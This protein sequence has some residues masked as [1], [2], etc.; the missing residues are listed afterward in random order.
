MRRNLKVV[1]ASLV[2]V[3]VTLAC[4]ISSL[5]QAVLDNTQEPTATAFPVLP[6][7]TRNLTPAVTGDLSDLDATLTELYERVNPGVVFIQTITANG[8]GLGSGFVYDKAGHIITNYHVVEGATTVEVDFPSGL[9]LFGDVIATDGDTDLAIIK[10]QTNPDNLVPLV[11]GDSEALKVGQTVVA[12]GNPFGLSGT[13]TLGIISAKGRVLSSVREVPGSGGYYSAGDILQTDASINPGNSGGPLLNINGEVVGINRAIEVS[14]VTLDGSAVNS[15]IGYAISINLVKRV[16]PAL[17]SKGVYDYPY[18]GITPIDELNLT[19]MEALGI[20][21]PNGAY[22]LGVAEGGPADK[23]GI[24]GG[25]TES[26]I[27]GL[28][29]GGDL[30]IGMDGIPVRNFSEL[31]SYMINYKSPGD[32]MVLTIIRDNREMEVTLTLEKRP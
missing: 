7:P 5:D 28:Y 20:E 8:S 10:V 14:G 27:T 3:T 22:V 25:T 32:K 1:L 29:S 9:K 12:I 23:A 15:G 4:S 6:T 11:L 2:L 18:L 31:I 24:K 16:V 30:I 17:I 13:M 19:M 26:S 21:Y